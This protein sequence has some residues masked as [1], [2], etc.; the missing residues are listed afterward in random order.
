MAVAEPA[1][2]TAR[3][4][5]IRYSHRADYCLRRFPLARCRRT[6][7]GFNH[8]HVLHCVL[9]RNWDLTAFKHGARE[10]V[11]LKRVLV[12]H[13]K[14]FGGD[15]GS[16]CVTSVVDKDS[17]RAVR[18]SVERDFDLNAPFGPEKLAALIGHELH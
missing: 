2:A 17:A 18:W 5:P 7:N 3:I 14:C 4:N 15:A 10:S 6:E 8:R 16:E 12:T 1:T 11:S 9:E 13:G